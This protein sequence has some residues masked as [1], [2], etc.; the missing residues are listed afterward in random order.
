MPYSEAFVALHQNPSIRKAPNTGPR[1]KSPKTEPDLG[2]DPLLQ[3]P[4]SLRG[5]DGHPQMTLCHTLQLRQ[6]S[7]RN[8]L[9]QAP[10]APAVEPLTQQLPGTV[11]SQGSLGDRRAGFTSQGSRGGG[12]AG[13][14]SQG[15]RGDRRAGFTSQGSRG[16][17]RA[18]FTSQGSRGDRRAGFTSQ[19]SRGDRRAA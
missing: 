11:A 9:H 7:Q 3:G 16:D 19:G 12:R 1:K 6:A 18:G 15:S 10:K 8:K 5:N 13:F 14:T 17:R 4:L 2:D